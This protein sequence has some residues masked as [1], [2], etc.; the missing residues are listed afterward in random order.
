MPG[1]SVTAAYTPFCLPQTQKVV[2]STQ[3]YWLL[4]CFGQ[5]YNEIHIVRN[6]KFIQVL[7]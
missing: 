7:P 4:V 3:L 2:V 1:F 5:L 6:W